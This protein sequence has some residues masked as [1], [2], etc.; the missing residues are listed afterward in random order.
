MLF[1]VLVH[2]F[3]IAFSYEQPIALKRTVTH[4]ASTART[5]D[6]RAVPVRNT[7]PE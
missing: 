2:A 3:F 7:N 1:F 4:H 6:Q 5:R